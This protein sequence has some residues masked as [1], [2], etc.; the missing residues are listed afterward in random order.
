MGGRLAFVAMHRE[1]AVPLLWDVVLQRVVQGHTN[2]QL[3][4]RKKVSAPRAG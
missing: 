3:Q 1:A 4:T 2:V